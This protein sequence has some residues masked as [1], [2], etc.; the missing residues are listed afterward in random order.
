MTPPD[1]DRDRRRLLALVYGVSDMRSVAVTADY[2]NGI[3]PFD[4]DE[5]VRRTIEAG[6]IVVYSRPFIASHGLPKL[7]PASNV[8]KHS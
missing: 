3:P 7:S 4:L 6:V 1:R 5:R 2:L 8:G